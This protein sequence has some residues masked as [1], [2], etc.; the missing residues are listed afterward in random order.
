MSY[1][2]NSGRIYIMWEDN[3]VINEQLIPSVG[4][5]FGK[6]SLNFNNDFISLVTAD[7]STGKIFI[8]TNTGNPIGINDM[9]IDN[10]KMQFYPNPASGFIEVLTATPC[11][12]SIFDSNGKEVK[13]IAVKSNTKIDVSDLIKG[14]YIA[15][16]AD[17]TTQKFI[18]E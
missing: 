1:A 13:N 12:I 4:T 18:K 8:T 10:S 17:G 16:S 2:D 7:E 9:T 14:V 5:Y 3:G 6:R 11:T 15:K